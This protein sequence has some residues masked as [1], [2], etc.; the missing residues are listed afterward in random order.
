MIRLKMAGITATSIIL[1]G[2][3][4]TVYGRFEGGTRVNTG[5]R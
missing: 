5:S 1:A 4:L 3:P 2:L